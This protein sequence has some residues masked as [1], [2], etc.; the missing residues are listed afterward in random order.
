VNFSDT[1]GR[2]YEPH[3]C[4]MI[5]YFKRWCSPPYGVSTIS[6]RTPYRWDFIGLRYGNRCSYSP[7]RPE[8]FDFVPACR[9]HDYGYELIRRGK[10]SSRGQVDS[11]FHNL[12]KNGTCPAYSG[13]T[14]VYVNGWIT[15]VARRTRC[16]QWADRYY[17]GVNIFGGIFL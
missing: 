1:T 11:Y 2:A 17:R 5:D 8:G 16:N 9:V 10:L 14:Y 7:D 13:Y 3:T 6:V 4:A 12:L 15:K